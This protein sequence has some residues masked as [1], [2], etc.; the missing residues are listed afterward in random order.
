M[1]TKTTRVRCVYPRIVQTIKILLE[2][3]NILLKSDS[4][5]VLQFF[6]DT[7]NTNVIG[8]TCLITIQSHIG[9][10][11]ITPYST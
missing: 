7:L 1:Y 11:L 3:G 5:K 9:L 6:R 8:V 4:I 2:T 10:R